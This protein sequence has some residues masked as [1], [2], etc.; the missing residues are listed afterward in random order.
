M[1]ASRNWMYH[2]SGE[3]DLATT[4]M[5]HFLVDS[6]LASSLGHE[7]SVRE[8]TIK[9]RNTPAFDPYSWNRPYNK[10][11]IPDEFPNSP[12]EVVQAQPEL[13]Q[14]IRVAEKRMYMLA[15]LV[16]NPIPQPQKVKEETRFLPY[17]PKS[18]KTD[19]VRSAESATISP[20]S[21]PS[22]PSPLADMVNKSLGTNI[23]YLTAYLCLI[24]IY[25]TIN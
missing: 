17:Y 6:V 23:L 11:T 4:R 22:V 9:Y 5:S 15:E 25:T 1:S 24:H 18:K 12:K 3:K 14:R 19:E 8:R 2:G 13:M 16:P 7:P 20:F 21:L 10:P